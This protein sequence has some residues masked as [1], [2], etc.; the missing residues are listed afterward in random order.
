MS[1]GQSGSS[2]RVRGTRSP[3]KRAESIFGIIPARAGNTRSPSTVTPSLRDHPRACGE[4][5]GVSKKNGRE[6]GSSPRVRGTPIASLRIA[7]RPRIIPARAGNTVR[8]Q[9]VEGLVGDHPRA[10]GEHR[11]RHCRT[12]R[13]AGSSPRVRGT[14]LGALHGD[15]IRG[16]IPARAGNTMTR[17]SFYIAEGDHPRA[18]GEHLDGDALTTWCGGSSPRVRGTHLCEYWHCLHVGI[19][20]ARAGNTKVT[21]LVVIPVRDHPRACG[22]HGQSF[23]CLSD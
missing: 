7:P 23:L 22:E 16:I 13:T 14:L 19:I 2:P 17:I 1:G 12:G 15:R 10:C 21:Q 9:I 6:W 8:V 20:P 11:R 18:C 4:H 3:T 5:K